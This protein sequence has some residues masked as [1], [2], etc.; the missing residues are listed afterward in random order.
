MAT[1][2]L[3]LRTLYLTRSICRDQPTTATLCDRF[4]LSERQVHR[5]MKEAEGLGARF[6]SVRDADGYRWRCTNADD[7][8]GSGLLD[9]WI[10]LE[11]N[12]SLV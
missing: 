5:V 3:R 10:D 2:H 7:I 11:E 1:N 9:E 8:R 4:H 6:E 12:A